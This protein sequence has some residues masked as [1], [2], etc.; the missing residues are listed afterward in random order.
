MIQLAKF[1]KPATLKQLFILSWPMAILVK[2]W[3]LMYTDLQNAF[4]CCKLFTKINHKKSYY[5]PNITKFKSH[6]HVI[7]TNSELINCES[8]NDSRA[9]LKKNPNRQRLP[10]DD[11]LVL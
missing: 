7:H 9:K 4:L 6:N 2:F 1:Y 11:I 8:E 5:L 10:N 3:N